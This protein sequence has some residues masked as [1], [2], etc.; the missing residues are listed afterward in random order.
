MT[1]TGL[2]S[3]LVVVN[4][5]M[6]F[7]SALKFSK[8]ELKRNVWPNIKS[9]LAQKFGNTKNCLTHLVT[10][11]ISLYSSCDCRL[12]DSGCLQNVVCVLSQII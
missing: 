7:R 1:G 4:R 6:L 10:Q 11:P 3:S 5:K 8:L 2:F 9:P 12:D